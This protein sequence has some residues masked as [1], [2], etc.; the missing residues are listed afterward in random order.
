M[1]TAF[2]IAIVAICIV[3]DVIIYFLK[4]GSETIST[5][6]T[7]AA[8]TRPGGALIPFLAGLLAGHLFFNQ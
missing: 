2:I 5:K 4:G 3:Y 7:N 6:I 8:Y 1:T